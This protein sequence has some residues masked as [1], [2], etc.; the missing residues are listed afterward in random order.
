MQRLS[1]LV[2]GTTLIFI[3]VLVGGCLF[4]WW[5]GAVFLNRMWPCLVIMPS[6]L[7]MKQRGRQLWSVQLIGNS[8]IV[9]LYTWSFLSAQSLIGWFL[10]YSSIVFGLWFIQKSFE[11]NTSEQ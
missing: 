6:F 1:E 7:A 9:L 11:T 2:G 8:T 10:G 5:T 3:G 4:E